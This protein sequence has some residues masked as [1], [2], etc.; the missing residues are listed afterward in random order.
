MAKPDYYSVS[1]EIVSREDKRAYKAE[2]PLKLWYC[3][4]VPSVTL[5]EADSFIHKILRNKYVR[6]RFDAEAKIGLQEV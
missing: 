3:K 4:N 2:H 6:E 5:A 1:K